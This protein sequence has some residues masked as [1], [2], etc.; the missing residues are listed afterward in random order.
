MQRRKRVTVEDRERAIFKYLKAL[1]DRDTGAT[2]KTIWECV[3]ESLGDAVTQQAYYKVLDRLQA[4]GKLDLVGDASS[5]GS[6]RYRI[7]PH[8]HADNAVSLDDVYELLETLAPSDAIARVLDARQYFEERRNSTLRAAA[9]AMLQ[10]DPRDLVARMVEQR[11]EEVR[12]DVELLRTKELADREL[13]ARVDAQLRDV[14][15][16]VYRYLGLSREAVDVAKLDEIRVADATIAINPE[17]LRREL[18]RRIFGNTFI[19]TVDASDAATESDL[20]RMTVGGSD[21]STHASVMQ[22]LTAATFA[23]DVGHPV[24]TFNNSVVYV[25]V[26]PALKSAY[27]FPYYSVPMTRASIDD[28]NNSGMVLAPFMFRYLSESEYEHMAKCATDVVQWRADER[29]F[30]GKARSLGDQKLLPRPLVHFRDGTITPQEREFGHYR[31]ENEYG[32]MVREGIARSRTILDAIMSTKRS[33]VFAGAVKTTQIRLFSMILNWYI[34]KGSRVGDGP[35]LDPNW[36]TTRAAH[37]SDN[38]S[39]TLLLSSLQDRRQDGVYY[40]TCVIFRPFHT[41][42][43]FFRTPVTPDYDWVADFER[44]RDWQL[45]AYSEGTETELPYLASVSDLSDEN[46]VVML[47]RADYATF[48]IGHTAGDPPPIAPRYE[49]LESVRQGG[50]TEVDARVERNKR[51]VVAALH[52]TGLAADK[53]HNFL[54]KKFLVR[55][56]PF[57]IS[58]AHEKCKALGRSLEAEFKSI[59]IANLQALRNSRGIRESEVKFLPVSIRRFIE[60]YKQALDA[61]GWDPKQ[62]P[63]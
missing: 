30:L 33:P 24:V 63:R 11:V 50:A 57:V 16:L 20:G 61:D 9:E 45:R 7:A 56:I 55:I 3:T 23:D 38:E 43:E 13:E 54:S 53:E 10:E 22:L 15:L 32:Y 18:T 40:T 44:R 27:D 39:M 12:T 35:P 28:P 51:L 19:S 8:L 25:D 21:G 17:A 37:I 60:R 2:V 34:T 47:Q 59:A 29:V 42:T 52:R 4:V 5:D 62:D 48:F 31:R 36:D 14:T 49:F 6:R 26:P 58:E 1:E 46:Y 41:L